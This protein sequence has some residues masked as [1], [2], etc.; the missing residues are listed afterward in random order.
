V[1]SLINGPHRE[2][3]ARSWC[4]DHASTQTLGGLPSRCEPALVACR[5]HKTSHEL[6]VVVT[7]DA[8]Q[9]GG[10][11]LA[12]GEVKATRSP[13]GLNASTSLSAWRTSAPCFRPPWPP[14][15]PASACSPGTSSPPT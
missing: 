6:D 9:T 10:R 14:P 11:I 3:L 2:D 5:E 13:V 4:V 8:P 1:A 7:A 15:R 12:I